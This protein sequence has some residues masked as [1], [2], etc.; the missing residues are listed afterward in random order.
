MT[1]I[2]TIWDAARA[3]ADWVLSGTQLASDSDLATA[4]IISVFSDRQAEADDAIP[5]LSDDARGWWADLDQAYRIGSRM[6]LLERSKK[7]PDVLLRAKDY[8]AESLQWLIDDGVV[9]R[10]DIVTEFFEN[11]LRAQV[12]AVRSDGATIAQNFAWVWLQLAPAQ[13]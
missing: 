2:A 7:T 11:Q 3:Q 6:W 10:F 13:V 9:L 12:V 1:D 5:D 8:L 4:I